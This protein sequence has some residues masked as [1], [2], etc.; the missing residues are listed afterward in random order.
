MKDLVTHKEMETL[1]GR[2]N[3]AGFIIPMAC[4][5]LGHLWT[6]MYAASH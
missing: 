1:I 4:H 2:L 6:A 5:F 3:H